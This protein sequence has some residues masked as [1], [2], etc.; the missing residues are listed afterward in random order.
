MRIVSLDEIR[1]AFDLDPA[2]DAVRAGFIAHARNQVSLGAVGYHVFPEA[3][4]DCHIKSASAK[5]AE[6]FVVKIATSFAGNADR[7]LPAGNGLMLLLSARTG[8]PLAL[9]Q[10]EGWLT[11]V[12]TAIAGALA[13]EAIRPEGASALGIVGTGVQARLQAEFTARRTGMRRI[14]LWGRRPEQAARLASSLV[15]SGLDARSVDSPADIAKAAD[16]VIT[17]TP[18]TE[19]LLT[20][21]MFARPARIVAV[22]ADAPGKQ[23]IAGDLTARMD[24]LIVD[25]I[26]Q[27]LDHGELSRP[28]AAGRIDTSRIR[29]LGDA[30]LDGAPFAPGQSVLVDLTGVGIQDLQIAQ[31]VWARLSS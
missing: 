25:S 29:R 15:S 21:E 26:D 18:S 24:I 22:G 12:R 8:Q 6:T 1:S 13:A 10:D 7:G 9:L 3:R 27:C 16:I 23:E 20:A 2:F 17:T 19:P 28:H 5:H 31:A 4:G 14:L 30:L 11:D